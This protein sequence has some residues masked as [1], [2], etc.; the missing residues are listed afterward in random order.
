MVSTQYVA[1]TNLKQ[2]LPPVL[3]NLLTFY[4]SI[5]TYLREKERKHRQGGGAEGK[6]GSRLPAVPEPKAVRGSVSKP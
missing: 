3:Q 2:V 1:L 5:F 6:K 4:I